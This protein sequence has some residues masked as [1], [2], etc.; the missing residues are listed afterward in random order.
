[1]VAFPTVN[2]TVKVR[3]FPEPPKMEIDREDLLYLIEWV[4]DIKYMDK[5]HVNHLCKKY[6][7]GTVKDKNGNYRIGFRDQDPETFDEFANKYDSRY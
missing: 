2:R 4:G 5:T 3:V 7:I 6:K 1:M